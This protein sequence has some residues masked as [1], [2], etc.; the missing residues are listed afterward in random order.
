MTKKNKLRFKI[1]GGLS[2]I[3]DLLKTLELHAE[4]KN[5]EITYKKSKQRMDTPLWDINIG[6]IQKD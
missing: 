3:Q 6:M 2:D 1:T 5:F 4:L